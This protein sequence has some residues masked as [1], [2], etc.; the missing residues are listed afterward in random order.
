MTFQPKDM[1]S[2]EDIDKRTKD[3][4]EQMRLRSLTI[5]TDTLFQ[6]HRLAALA[7]LLKAKGIITDEEVDYYHRLARMVDFERLVMEHDQVSK[8]LIIPG[9]KS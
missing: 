3:A 5:S 6:G 2:V 7:T 9:R 8:S 4:V 1:P